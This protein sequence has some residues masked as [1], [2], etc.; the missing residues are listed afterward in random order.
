MHTV[1]SSNWPSA[2]NREWS[3]STRGLKGRQYIN[4]AFLFIAIV[5]PCFR[6]QHGAVAPDDGGC[7]SK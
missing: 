7:G 6:V 4:I 3:V 1:R 5:L 2:M